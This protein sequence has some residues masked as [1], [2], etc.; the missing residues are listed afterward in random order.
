MANFTTTQST[1]LVNGGEIICSCTGATYNFHKFS[2]FDNGNYYEH[3]TPTQ[4]DLSLTAEST[5]AESQAA[6]IA[7]FKTIERKPV[8]VEPTITVLS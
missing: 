4:S 2:G 6:F 5:L 8:K 1:T 3:A 7:H